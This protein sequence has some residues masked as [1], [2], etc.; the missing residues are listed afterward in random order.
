VAVTVSNIVTAPIAS[1]QTFCISATV[2]DIVA[3][4][5]S[6]KWYSV[7]TGGTPLAS[8]SALVTGNYY[9]SQTINSIE[10]PRT[11]VLVTIYA[12]PIAK[13]INSPTTLGSVR[14]PIC[15][16]AT[17]VLNVRQGYSATKI[18]WE[19]AVVPLN[20]NVVPASTDYTLINGAIG[21]SYTVT[22]AIAGKNFF[23]AKFINGDCDATAVYSSP[24][25]V[26]YNECAV[27]KLISVFSY[28]NPYSENFNLNLTTTSEE[29]VGVSVYDM[30]GKLMEE[31][32]LNLSEVA[33]F[34]TGQRYP[35]GI[36]NIV[37]N[38]GGET[39][40]IKVIK[41]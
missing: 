34:N 22:T 16:S 17:K 13:S 5:I 11:V 40:T 4:G 24:I 38:Q 12:A 18:L 19:T 6:L 39:L 25:I 3:N 20:S 37:V 28:P 8:T 21:P 1:A 23:R 27:N 30:T 33:D 41:K 14:Y 9:V 35:S 15:T 7:A 31:R 10:G 29:K 2:A 36:Y 32:E 26:Y